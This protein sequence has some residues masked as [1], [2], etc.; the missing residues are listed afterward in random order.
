[1]SEQIKVYSSRL[2]GLTF[3]SRKAFIASTGSL[4]LV[5]LRTASLSTLIKTYAFGHGGGC[6]LNWPSRND[7]K[8]RVGYVVLFLVP[9]GELSSRDWVLLGEFFQ[10]LDSWV[11]GVYGRGE[12]AVSKK[13]RSVNFVMRTLREE[14]KNIHVRLCVFVLDFGVMLIPQDPRETKAKNVRHSRQ[15][16]RQAK[17]PASCLTRRASPWRFL[18]REDDEEY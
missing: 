17:L 4:V 5:L 14:G 16:C 8:I 2:S 11:G 9:D 18:K 12:G 7:S 15:R 6:K 10:L 3:I 1:M 13:K